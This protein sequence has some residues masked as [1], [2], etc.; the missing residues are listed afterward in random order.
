MRILRAVVSLA[1][2]VT[3]AAFLFFYISNVSKAD[4]TYPEIKIENE[5]IDVSLNADEKEL[6][7]GVTAF[8]EKDGDITDKIVIESV[9]KFM[10]KGVSLVTYSVCD[11]DN[12]VATETRKINY[13]NYESPKFYMKESLVFST[14]EHVVLTDYIGATD[15]IDGDI[16][17]SLIVTTDDYDSSKDGTYK[18]AV[19]AANSKGDTIYL[20]LPVVVKKDWTNNLHINLSDYLIYIS[21][22][23]DIDF[24]KYVES[25]TNQA[26]KKI[27]SNM[28]IKTDFNKDK[29]GT[30]SVNYYAN[31]SDGSTGH[32][33]LTVIV[34]G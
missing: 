30:Y 2:V 26:N 1:F 20:N 10:Q 32:T 8:D 33:I 25:T 11:A 19:Q 16:S 28:N 7:K 5:F 24:N 31:G 27:K 22:G 9:S 23:K 12:H 14:T 3:L 34:E 15:V 18:I 13:K 17:D 29:P 21:Q 4:K 6:M